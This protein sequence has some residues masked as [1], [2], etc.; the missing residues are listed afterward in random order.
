MEFYERVSG[1]RMHA[2][3]YRFGH[4]FLN[5]LPKNLLFDINFF[6]INNFKAVNEINYLLVNN[7]V[8]KRRL[9]GVGQINNNLVK[10]YNVTGVLARSAGVKHDV[11]INKIDSYSNYPY[12]NITSFTTKNGDCFDR[13]VLRVAEI[14]ECLSIIN[15]LSSVLIKT[16]SNNL[17][18]FKSNK[19]KVYRSMESLIRHFKYWTEGVKPS[20]GSIVSSVESAK[21]E[22]SVFIDSVGN[23]KPNRVRVR[24]PAYYHMQLAVNLSKGNLLADLI[25]LIG[26][27]DIVFGEVDR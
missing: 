7:K 13:Y 3:F 19:D 27:L 11:R 1:A 8:W 20:K 15:K 12:L 2:A 21:G 10:R 18:P 6:V 23:N 16:N 4:N 5:E 14:Y 26:T 22:F 17:K 25:T 24:S 9:V